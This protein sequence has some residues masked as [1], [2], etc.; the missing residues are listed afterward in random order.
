M[1]TKTF[2]IPVKNVIL[3]SPIQLYV[4]DDTEV[5]GSEKERG[6]VEWEFNPLK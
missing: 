1:T 2:Q 4:I 5:L 6:K 3:M